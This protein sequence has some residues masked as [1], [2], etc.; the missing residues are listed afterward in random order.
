MR[1]RQSIPYKITEHSVAG[2]RWRV[3]R[4]HYD[5]KERKR[6]P[7]HPSKR[8]LQRKLNRPQLARGT[9]GPKL[10]VG[11]EYAEPHCALGRPRVRYRCPEIFRRRNIDI[12][13]RRRDRVIAPASAEPARH[14][15][16]KRRWNKVKI[17]R[18]IR[19]HLGHAGHTIPPVA[20]R[21][22]RLPR[23]IPGARGNRTATRPKTSSS[24][25][26]D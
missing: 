11:A 1:L 24:R 2:A 19:R 12:P 20:V 8:V 6:Y 18:W 14:R 9:V 10:I 16:G 4:S 26:P 25:R 21:L 17:R 3:D 22:N 13:L 23:R 15:I 7:R 5:F